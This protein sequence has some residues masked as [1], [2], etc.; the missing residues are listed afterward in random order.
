MLVCSAIHISSRSTLFL[1]LSSF[2]MSIL[3]CKH[4]T[5]RICIL[6]WVFKI[7]GVSDFSGLSQRNGDVFGVNEGV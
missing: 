6:I 4:L 3:V 7:E 2:C 1:Q 5:Y